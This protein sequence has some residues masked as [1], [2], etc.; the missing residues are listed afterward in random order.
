MAVDDVVK[1]I[2]RSWQDWDGDARHLVEARAEIARLIL[3][4]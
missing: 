4:K 3:A 1:K 2:A